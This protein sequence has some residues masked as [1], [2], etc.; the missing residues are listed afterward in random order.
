MNKKI[1][2][3]SNIL[4][5]IT[6]F[7]LGLIKALVDAGYEVVC[8]ADTDDFSVLSETKIADA[9][10]RFI[11][12]VMNRKGTNPFSDLR[13]LFKLKK[14]IK[15]EKP[16]IVINYTIK[17][18]IYGS[19][20]ARLLHIP[21]LAVTTGLGF[22]FNSNNLL[23]RITRLLY[24]FSLRFPSKV[25][26][27]NTD[28]REIFLHN[29]IIPNEKASLLP[30][31]G[32]DTEYYQPIPTSPKDRDFTFLL[33]ARLLWEKGVGEYA[34]AA[35]ILRSDNTINARFMLIGYIDSDNPGGI[36]KTQIQQWSDEGIIEYC[37][38]AED[39]R[40]IISESDCVVLPSYYREGV[41]RTL[42]EAAS[43]AKPIITTDNVGCREVIDDGINGFI[44]KTK[45]STN[46]SEVMRRMIRLTPEKREKMG[47][48]GRNKILNQFDER[49][50]INIYLKEIEQ[51]L[52][53][54]SN[55]L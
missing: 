30:S 45:D 49:I 22:V 21:S 18:V 52:N 53:I 13:Y 14:I 25:F 17:P 29:R 24:K 6:Q 43:M 20:S 47:Q 4:W 50:V 34:E 36:S 9:G 12:L 46:L 11:R 48:S 51:A 16:V 42:L 10:A 26:F 55:Y 41:P 23:T 31:E 54:R 7:R 40:N 33:I 38:T 35:R 2:L 39:I 5:T 15:L 3:C 28:D 8:V 32:I 44:C 1:L 37:G 19:I 27:L